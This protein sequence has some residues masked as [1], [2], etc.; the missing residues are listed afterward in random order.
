VFHTIAFLAFSCLAFSTL[1]IWCRKFMSRI[2]HPCILVP[3]FHVPQFHVSH[4]QRPRPNAKKAFSSRFQR[5]EIDTLAMNVLS[6]VVLL[7]VC[8]DGASEFIKNST[9][10]IHVV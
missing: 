7:A 2:F 10:G 6:H 8:C 9:S 5:L 3:H 1:A 4:F